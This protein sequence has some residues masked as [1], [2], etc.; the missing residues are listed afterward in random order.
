MSLL[1][2]CILE[3]CHNNDLPNYYFYFH[4]WR[5]RTS[6]DLLTKLLVLYFPHELKTHEERF[7]VNNFNYLKF[8]QNNLYSLIYLI[9][10]QLETS[11]SLHYH[12][13]V[14]QLNTCDSVATLQASC[15]TWLDCSHYIQHH[16]LY[17]KQRNAYT[18]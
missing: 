11:P 1:W 15:A 6:I 14:H 8:L 16:C 7:S 12:V 4:R 10:M 13:H 5:N 17:C 2:I 18:G 9:I 3:L